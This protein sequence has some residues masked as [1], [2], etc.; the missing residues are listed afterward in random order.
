MAPSVHPSARPLTAPLPACQ[1]IALDAD[2]DGRFRFA[3]LQSAVGR[4]LLVAAGKAPDDISSIVLV[5]RPGD[6]AGVHFKS[7]AVLR[8]AQ[9][10]SVVLSQACA[11]PASLPSHKARCPPLGPYH[12]L[13]PFQ[14]LG[15]YAYWALGGL[16]LLAP[17]PLRDG[18]YGVV[19][20]N[21]YRFFGHT[22]DACRLG[23]AGK[24]AARFVADDRVGAE[25]VAAVAPTLAPAAA[26][27]AAAA[28]VARG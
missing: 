5:Q 10:C 18:V 3:A 24:Y 11:V 7:D 8:I 12:P 20:R 19:A 15:G 4:V 13:P 17:T 14:G 22:A 26:A 16:G 1:N 6:P 28:A 21:R 9:A 23:D 25:A 2:P 27:A